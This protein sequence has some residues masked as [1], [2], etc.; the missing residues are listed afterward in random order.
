MIG[1]IW[2]RNRSTIGIYIKEWSV[3]WEVV[4]TYLSDLDLTQEYLDAERPQI[5]RDAE[6]DKVVILVDGKDFMI[7]DPKKNSAMK[8]AVWSD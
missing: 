8:K 6:Q 5:L 3:R 2:S 1:A 7:D 4:G